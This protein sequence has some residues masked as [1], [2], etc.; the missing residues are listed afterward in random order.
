MKRMLGVLAVVCVSAG[1]SV[2][3]PPEG[4]EPVQ[5]FELKSYLGTWYEIA[6]M[7]HSFERGMDQVKAEYSLNEN[8]SVRVVNSGVLTAKDK[9]KSATGK[10]FFTGA[11]D[12]GSLKVSFFG[13]F[14]GG[15]YIFDL[16]PEEYSLV[17]SGTRDYLW[18]LSRKKTLSAKRTQQLMKKAA[19]AGY[20]TNALIWVR[21]K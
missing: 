11:N 15:Y 9:K 21:Q 2:K 14:Y 4:V 16:D 1:C 18:I 20:D 12:V 13:P 6:R 10:A 5:D 19:A 8:G 17:A 3:P 7:D